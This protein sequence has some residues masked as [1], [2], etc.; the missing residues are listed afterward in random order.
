MRT[1]HPKWG[2]YRTEATADNMS[3]LHVE[4]D[5]RADML[6][7]MLDRGEVE[8]VPV[9]SAA[10]CGHAHRTLPLASDAN[11]PPKHRI[12]KMRNASLALARR[13]G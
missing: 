10:L 7:A 1:V 2:G 13:D 12:A 8:A 11:M 4:L 3:A 5:R 9:P 6:S